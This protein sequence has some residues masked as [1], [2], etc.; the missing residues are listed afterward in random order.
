LVLSV[1]YTQLGNEVISTTEIVD[2]IDAGYYFSVNGAMMASKNF[3]EN[4]V[5]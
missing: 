2:A 3:L 5:A 4:L 1:N